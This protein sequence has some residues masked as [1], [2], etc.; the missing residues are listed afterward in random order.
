MDL[1]T[2]IQNS[3]LIRPDLKERLLANFDKLT[4]EQKAKIDESLDVKPIYDQA[5]SEAKEVG[6]KFE[7]EI[8]KDIE[9]K[10]SEKADKN[11]EDALNNL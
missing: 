1:K 3:T 5:I 7:K 4:D 8:K 10:E 2:K 9:V 11:V 6:K